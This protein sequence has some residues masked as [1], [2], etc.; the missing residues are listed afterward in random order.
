MSLSRW[1]YR[2]GTALL[3]TYGE[4]FVPIV[5]FIYL[6]WG[7]GQLKDKNDSLVQRIS[8]IKVRE[9][10]VQMTSHTKDNNRSLLQRSLTPK[11][12]TDH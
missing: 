5:T 8:Y 2:Q 11:T 1:I 7:H 10:L 9:S 3:F 12:I 4:R 6:Q